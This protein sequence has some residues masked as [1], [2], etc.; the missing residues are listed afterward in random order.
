MK[1][2][3]ISICMAFCLAITAMTGCGKK[4][5]KEDKKQDVT[6]TVWN[7]YNGAQLE[8]FNKLVDEFN[9]TAGKEKGI[10]VEAASHGSVE[11]LQNNVL[12]SINGV[13]GAEAVPNIFAAYSDTA[14]EIDQM[15]R[16]VDLKQYFTEKELDEYVSGYINE[17]Y[18]NQSDELKILPIAKST[19]IL[20][21]NMT[22]WEKFAQATATSV[23]ELATYEGVTS[24]AQKYYEWTDALTDTPND[25]KA[26]L[27]RDAMANYFIVGFKQFGKEL[28]EVQGDGS[29]KVNFDK[30][31]VRKLWDNYYVPYVKGYFTLS[32][33]FGSDDVKTGTTIAF[34]GSTSG[35]SFFPE[36][37]SVSDTETYEITNE[38]LPSPVFE[39]QQPVSV[40]QGAGM[41]VTKATKAEEEASVEFLKWFTDDEHNI[42]FS[43]ES[44]YLPVKKDANSKTVMEQYTGQIKSTVRKTIETGIETVNSRELYTTSA[45]RNGSEARNILTYS[46]SDLARADREKIETQIQAGMSNEE[47]ITPYLSDEYF[48]TWYDKTKSELENCADW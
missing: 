7:Y 32:G 41:V 31:I 5:E 33:R 17:G 22:D 40:Q 16:L 2:Q 26:F 18:F 27:G 46:L 15:D 4:S 14:Y 25:G 20:F 37:V 6:I 47:A 19:E 34:I 35:A 8:S 39:G 13:A 9:K 42:E 43:V 23:D 44:G 12:D 38:I 10:V 48:E 30:E 11:D 24:V 36:E 1:K 45:F 29:V 28:F 21:L 3:W